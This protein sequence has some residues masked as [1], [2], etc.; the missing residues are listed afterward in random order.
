MSNA[1]AAIQIAIT[2]GVIRERAMTQHTMQPTA[3]ALNMMKD[4]G[5]DTDCGPAIPCLK[6]ARTI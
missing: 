1:M 4:S 2:A 6:Q 5:T 3:K